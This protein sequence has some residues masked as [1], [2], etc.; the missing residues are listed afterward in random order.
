[1]LQPE[2]QAERERT[3]QVV[4]YPFNSL[5]V[6]VGGVAIKSGKESCSES[7]IGPS[8]NST[9]HDRSH[10]RLVQW[11][12][13]TERSQLPSSSTVRIEGFRF[14]ERETF[15]GVLTASVSAVWLEP[16]ADSLELIPR[17]RSR[18]SL[19]ADVVMRSAL[20]HRPWISNHTFAKGFD[21]LSL[22]AQRAFLSIRS[23]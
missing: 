10:D 14:D 18:P 21:G 16:G 4:E 7:E 1:V 12:L 9:P 22:Q 11:S 15:H 5:R 13:L 19:L 2:H 17:P 8:A 3:F 23:I 20:S 6:L